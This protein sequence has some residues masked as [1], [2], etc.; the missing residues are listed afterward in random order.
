MIGLVTTLWIMTT[1]FAVV[2]M[3]RGWTRAVIATA[4]LILSL[5]AINQ[6]APFLFGALG[7][8]ELPF[9][10]TIWRRQIFILTTIHLVIAFFSY[11]G[12]AVAGGRL[13]GKLRIRDNVQDKLLALL[14]GAVNGYLTIGT[15]IAFLESRL[16]PEG[17]VPTTPAPYPFPADMLIRTEQVDAIS[18]YLPIPLLTNNPYVLPVLLVLVF[19]FVLIVML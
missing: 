15:L 18:K 1:F 5:F 9:D 12:P 8:F 11:A 3:Q 13:A 10:E 7:Y 2:D 19:L 14:V 17:W 16:T 4:G 6:F